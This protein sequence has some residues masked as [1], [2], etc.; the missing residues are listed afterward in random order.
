MPRDTA[1]ASWA[2]TSA[3]RA[4]MQRQPTR[5]TQPELAVRRIIHASGLRFRIDVAPLPGLRRRADVVFRTA[6][7]ALFVD[8]CFWHGCPEHGTRPTKSNP[9]YWL[10]KIERNRARDQ[11]TDARLEAAGWI[12]LRAW[13]HEE[14]SDVAARTI[15]IVKSR[16]TR[17]PLRGNSSG[18]PDVSASDPGVA[19]HFR[20][21][22]DTTR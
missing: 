18:E 21:R 10:A 16:R 22:R 20:Q 6:R 5:D 11:D 4:R 13:E 9:E 19:R 17:S 12:S 1:D 15:A 14:P 2:S 7:V 8:G 3:V